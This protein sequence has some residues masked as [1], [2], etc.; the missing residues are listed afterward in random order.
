MHMKRFMNF[1]GLGVDAE[2]RFL[3]DIRRA[4][5]RAD[6]FAICE[7]FLDHDRPTP[8]EPFQLALKES[9]LLAGV[10]R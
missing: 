9:D 8:L 6:F 10:H 3:H 1:I 4:N 7:S 2:G 5:T